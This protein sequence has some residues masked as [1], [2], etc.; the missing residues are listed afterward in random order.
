ML[1]RSFICFI[2]LFLFS[3]AG[4]QIRQD[5]DVGDTKKTQEIN[6]YI[7]I[8]SK[9][10]GD[11]KKA[12]SLMQQGDNEKAIEKL[13]TVIERESRLPAPFV[14]IAIAY[15]KLGESKLAEENL[16]KALK[17]DIGHAAANNELALLYR[18]QGK[19]KAARI[20]YKNALNKHPEHLLVIRNLGVLCDIY[21][22]DY[23]C[24]L[25]QFEH[26]LSL[27]PDDKTVMIWVA[28]VKHRLKS[29]E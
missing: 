14:N 16:V 26:Y 7:E 6:A 5:T 10:E 4:D 12:V 28:D 17:L 13:K 23:E 27:Q 15:N 9:V 21:L 2:S 22:R 24:A 20:A 3:C 11:F 8:D 19:F 25:D 29:S 1:Y 18:K